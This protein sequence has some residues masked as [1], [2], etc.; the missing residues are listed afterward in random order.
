MPKQR[1]SVKKTSEV[2][3]CEIILFCAEKKE[4]LDVVGYQLQCDVVA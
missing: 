2:I 4:K 1:L 3:K